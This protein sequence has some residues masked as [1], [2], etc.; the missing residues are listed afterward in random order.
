MVIGRLTGSSNS[1]RSIQIFHR[2]EV[3]TA[4]LPAQLDASVCVAGDIHAYLGVLVFFSMYQSL[5]SKHEEIRIA[6][7]KI[8]HNGG[9]ISRYIRTR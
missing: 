9:L 8:L 3:K 1:G 2:N 7:N 5:L 6:R 4:I